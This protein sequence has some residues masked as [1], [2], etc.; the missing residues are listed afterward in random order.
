[1]TVAAKKGEVRVIDKDEHL[2]ETSLEALAKL[3]GVVHPAGGVTAG[4]AS[5]VNDGACALLLANEAAAARHGLTPRALVVAMAT[6]VLAPR[7]MGKGP[8]LATCKVLELAGPTLAQMDVIEL[9]EASAAQGLAVL[10]DLVHDVHRCRPGHRAGSRAGVEAFCPVQVVRK[11]PLRP[12]IATTASSAS[13][14]RRG[15]R[16][17]RC[18]TSR[19][20]P[21][22]V[23][24]PGPRRG[25]TG[26]AAPLR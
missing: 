20:P 11:R 4:N 9:N 18:V 2:R 10:R 6:A 16:S 19:R 8:A 24:H 5:G 21:S 15:R 12:S 17:C 1:M 13:A 14:R 3:K 25:T 26:G 7:I 22:S 23:R